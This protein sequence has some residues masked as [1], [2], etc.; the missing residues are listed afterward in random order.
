MTPADYRH[1]RQLRGSQRTVALALGVD[2]QTIS[3]RERNEI[4]ITRE[5]WLALLALPLAGST[6]SPARTRRSQLRA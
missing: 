1:E 2:P 6:A 4:A 3:R 5:A